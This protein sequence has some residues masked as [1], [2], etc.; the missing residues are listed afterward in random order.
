MAFYDVDPYYR[1]VHENL[2]DMRQVTSS[3]TYLK[4]GWTLHMLRGLIGDE[5]FWRGIQAY[6]REH[7]DS[8]ASTDD[9]RRAM[10]EASGRDLSEFF[11]QWLY[12]GGKLKYQGGWGYE[13]GRLNIDLNQVQNDGYFF[14]MPVQIGIYYDG[15]LRPRIETLQVNE[16][17]NSFTIPLDRAPTNV[18][19][20]PNTWVLMEAEFFNQEA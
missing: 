10:E 3:N 14:Q 17:D 2:T 9:F 5:A 16:P 7:R 12:Q 11:Q 19:L 15:E 13:D 4:G 8:N 20:D 6:Y 18:V 1:V